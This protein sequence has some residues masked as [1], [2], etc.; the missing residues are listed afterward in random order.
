MSSSFFRLLLLI[1][2]VVAFGCG[3]TDSGTGQGSEEVPS[4]AITEPQP[5]TQTTPQPTT[6]DKKP[7]AGPATLPLVSEPKLS[8]SAEEIRDGWI[9]LFDGQTLAG[10]TSPTSIDWHVNENGEIEASQGDIGLLLT[11]VPFADYE[12][13]CD[14]WMA[15]GGNSG[16]FLRTSAAPQD[17]TTECY[18]LNICDSHPKFKTAS[19]VGRAQ[20]TSEVTGEEVW[21]SFH[22]RAEGRR[23]VVSLDGQ[24]VLDHTDESEGF[25]RSGLIGLQKNE[26]LIRF[27]NVF[28][29]PLGTQPI[30]NGSDLTGWKTVPGS[31]SEFSV[32]DG[33][34][35]V[36][37]GRGFLETEASWS[38][39]TLQFDTKTNG[40]GL[41]S[42]VFFRLMPSTEKDPS[43]GYELQIENVF[44]D[45]DRRLPKDDAG[46]G[47]IFR[48]TKARWVISN[49]HEWTTM[50]LIAHGP[51]IA[52][53]VN[54]FL[55]TDWEDDRKPEPNPR[56][57]LRVEAGPISLQGHDPSTRMQ[58]TNLRVA[59]FPEE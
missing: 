20:P 24:E 49:D 44:A 28:L 43:N 33:T 56:R 21:K 11:S 19:L 51:R 25:K 37:G 55:I 48:R 17:P 29:K 40:D 36:Q 41:N 58:F 9:Q 7:T 27:R 4:N 50:T 10:W 16:I 57:G 14:Y 12:L 5:E 23:I 45:G 34:I 1:P 8:L 15:T 52:S 59:A 3:G 35:V 30:F 26:G 46:T 2:V 38:D 31:E 6:A 39:F 54:G 53:W 18:E 22:V 32:A 47:A 42:G 13:R